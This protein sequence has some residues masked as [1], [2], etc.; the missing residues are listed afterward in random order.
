MQPTCRCKYFCPAMGNFSDF[1]GPCLRS[2][3]FQS[4]LPSDGTHLVG[5]LDI[6]TECDCPSSGLHP[7]SSRFISFTFWFDPRSS[8]ASHWL[9]KVW[10]CPI[11]L[12]NSPPMRLSLDF[13]L[14]CVSCNL[15]GIYSRLFTSRV[16]RC[17]WQ[18]ATRSSF[19]LCDCPYFCLCFCSTNHVWK[20]TLKCDDDALNSRAFF[21]GLH[22]EFAATQRWHQNVGLE[23]SSGKHI[24]SSGWRR[25]PRQVQD[26]LRQD[27]ATAEADSTENCDSELRSN[28]LKSFSS[29][30]FPFSF[31]NS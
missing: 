11:T 18:W 22:N 30:S 26:W 20:W 27:L 21:H 17:P 19:F 23:R 8:G 16:Y 12:P 4:V 13:N 1:P 25:R 29:K 14:P 15:V 6:A 5:F 3:L 10:S 9:Q 7:A 24:C 2:S 31:G 28:W